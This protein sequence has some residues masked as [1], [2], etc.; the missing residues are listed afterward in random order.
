MSS[1]VGFYSFGPAYYS[2]FDSSTRSRYVSDTDNSDERTKG[3]RERA[4]EMRRHKS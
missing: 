4:E 1:E 2:H 3:P